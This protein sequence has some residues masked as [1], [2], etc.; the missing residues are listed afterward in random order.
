MT[1]RLKGTH[2]AGN[3]SAKVYKDNE[4]NEHRVKFYKN[5]KHLGEGPEYHTD[6]VE[7]AHATAKAALKRYN[8]Y[9]GYN[10]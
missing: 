8:E 5:G 4:W 3:Y 9:D 6:D 2:T 7:D 1:L 10:K